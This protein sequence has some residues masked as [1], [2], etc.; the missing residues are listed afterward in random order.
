MT[1]SF[2]ANR[3]SGAAIKQHDVRKDRHQRDRRQTPK[4][5]EID[6]V[7][8]KVSGPNQVQPQLA[9]QCIVNA[10]SLLVEMTGDQTTNTTVDRAGVSSRSL[11]HR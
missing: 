7:P 9:A 2:V 5:V 11:K 10:K 6:G 8:A 3:A 4:H 1:M